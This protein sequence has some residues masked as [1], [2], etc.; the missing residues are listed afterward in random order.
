MRNILYAVA[1]CAAAAAR[2]GGCTRFAMSRVVAL[3]AFGIVALA[4]SG[5]ASPALAQ[6]APP[7]EAKWTFA[8]QPYLW[9]VGI[10][11]TVKYEIPPNSGGGADVGLSLAALPSLFII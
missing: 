11:G 5:I 1:A 7:P 4:A 10:D 2:A 6:T 3:A 8:V 9:L